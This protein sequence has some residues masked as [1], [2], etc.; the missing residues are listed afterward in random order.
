MRVKP[1]T[2]AWYVAVLVG[3]SLWLGWPGTVVALLAGIDLQRR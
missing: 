3:A 2:L 1:L